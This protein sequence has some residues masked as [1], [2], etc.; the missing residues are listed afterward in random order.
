VNKTT[1]V[2]SYSGYSIDLINEL[3]KDINFKY[4]IYEAPGTKQS[5][6]RSLYIPM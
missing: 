1:G 3:A 5:T 4:E 6:L 2:A